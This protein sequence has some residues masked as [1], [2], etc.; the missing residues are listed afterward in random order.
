MT[1]REAIQIIKDEDLKNYNWFDN[2]EVQPNEV[3]ITKRENVWIVATADERKTRIS[4]ISYKSES[5]ALND[6]IER[7]RADKVL[8]QYYK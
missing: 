5:E 4:T 3:E 7:L 8:N 2:H 1:E 6:F